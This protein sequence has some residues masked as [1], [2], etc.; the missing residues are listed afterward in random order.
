[1]LSGVRVR[2]QR[3]IEKKKNLISADR[4]RL[5]LDKMN[6]Y[7]SKILSDIRKKRKLVYDS[8]ILD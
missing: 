3:L 5:E 8:G 6:R 7:E 4:K 2:R 1:M